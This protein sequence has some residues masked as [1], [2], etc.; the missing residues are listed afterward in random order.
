A[1]VIHFDHKGGTMVS[2]RRRFRSLAEFHVGSYIFYRKHIQQSP[3]STMN[4]LV[5]FGI[6]C[7]F[8]LSMAAQCLA[9]LRDLVITLLG[10][11]SRKRRQPPA[12]ETGRRPIW[13]AAPS[14]TPAA[15]TAADC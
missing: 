9:E 14:S 15:K 7:R 5:A 6:F 11:V 10:R 2:M 12:P 1:R 4:I 3:W 8:L 13:R